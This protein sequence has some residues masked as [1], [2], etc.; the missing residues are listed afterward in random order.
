MFRGGAKISIDQA[1][2]LSTIDEIDVAGDIDARM[3]EDRSVIIPWIDAALPLDG[4]NS[5][6]RLRHWG[7][8]SRAFLVRRDK[9]GYRR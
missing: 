1:N 6:D 3:D 8:N 2:Y 5:R 9:H 4:A 7:I